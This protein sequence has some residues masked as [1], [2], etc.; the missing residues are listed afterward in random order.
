MK[1]S[2]LIVPPL[3]AAVIRVL[4]WTWR[5]RIRGREHLEE[6]RR[7]SSHVVFACWHGRLLPLVR[8]HRGMGV[9]VLASEHHDGELLG[10]TIRYFGFRTAP[11]SSTRGGA[12]GIL[13]LAD[14]ARAGHD[15]GLT[16]DGPR[17]PRYQV[18]PGVVEVA[19][20]SGGAIV[21]LTT[22][23]RRHRTFASWDAFELPAPFT[24]IV[25][26]YGAPIRV[27]SD[28]DREAMEATRKDVEAS[29]RAI[30]ESCDRDAVG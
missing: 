7:T 16:V 30:T 3:G 6:A 26:E 22:S 12:K 21:P 14:R 10:R 5:V 9:T 8:V 23:S 24:R 11:G 17:G 15:V 28:A 19:K 29:L 1:L 27:P 18:K 2:L 25:V 13:A 4:A 20:L